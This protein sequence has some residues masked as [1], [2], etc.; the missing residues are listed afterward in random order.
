[1]SEKQA[2]PA[3]STGRR[4][5]LYGRRQGHKLR[6]HQES[7]MAHL[8]PKLTVPLDKNNLSPSSLFDGPVEQ[9]WLEIGFGGGEHL[10]AQAAANPNVGLIGC[11]PFINGVAKLLAE[12]EA[13]ELTNVR[14]HHNDARDVLERLEDASLDRVFLLFPDP[15][16]KKRHHKRRFVSSETLDQLARIMK[17]GAEFRVATDIKNYSRWTLREVR[18]H[19]VFEWQVECAED[20]RIRP[21]DWPGTRYEAKAD[22]EGRVPVYLTFRRKPRPVSVE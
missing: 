15:W 3:D 21:D 17:D 12:V 18:A 7:L 10:V 2:P 9:V 5:L 6:S 16:H 8:L 22:R 20:W 1:M 11:E 13:K 19:G 4:R 14:I